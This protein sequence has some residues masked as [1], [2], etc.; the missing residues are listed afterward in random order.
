M[1]AKSV[2]ARNIIGKKTNGVT[3]V[4]NVNTELEYFHRNSPNATVRK[5]SQCLVLSYQK[6]KIKDLVSIFNVSRRTIER[7]YNS[8]DS[9][10]VDS[11]AV[12]EGRGAKTRLKDYSKEVSQQLELHCDNGVVDIF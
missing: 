10:G 3:S 11:L 7:W 8:W 2:I 1:F 4:K 9:I 5:R 6:H 12:T